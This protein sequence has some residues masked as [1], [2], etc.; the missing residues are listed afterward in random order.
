MII[1]TNVELT[2]SANQLKE[3][4][5]HDGVPELIV[6]LPGEQDSSSGLNV[7]CRRDMRDSFLDNRFEFGVGNSR[8]F[9]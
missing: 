6:G 1:A 2:V 7:E 9:R 8:G 5:L 4:W 3:T